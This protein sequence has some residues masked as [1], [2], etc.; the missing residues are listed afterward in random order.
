LL[1][2]HARSRI[3]LR[4]SQGDKPK[5]ERKEVLAMKWGEYS[6]KAADRVTN[7]ALKIFGSRGLYILLVLAALVILSGA[8]DKWAG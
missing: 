5:L 2:A 6:E 8:G 4:I 1:L 7:F 3:S